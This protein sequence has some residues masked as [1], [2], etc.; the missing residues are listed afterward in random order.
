[1][2]IQRILAS[3]EEKKGRAAVILNLGA[4]SRGLA[5]DLLINEHRIGQ[6][7]IEQDVVKAVIS[8]PGNLFYGT[9]VPCCLLL[10]NANKLP[11]REGKILFVDA[12]NTFRARRGGR[13]FKLEQRECD[14]ILEA[15]EQWKTEGNFS[16]VASL[17]EVCSNCF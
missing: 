16:G 9:T 6:A 4:L 1:M 15:N 10:F 13:R 2:W 8:L 12:L 3:L 17:D 14:A 11:D 5:S 7:V